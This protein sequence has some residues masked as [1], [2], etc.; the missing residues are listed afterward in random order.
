MDKMPE[1]IDAPT[2]N[3]ENN[4][5]SYEITEPEPELEPEPVEEVVEVV[6]RPKIDNREIFKQKKDSNPLSVEKVKKPKRQISEAQRENLKKAREKALEKRR[7]NAKARK[8]GTLPTKKQQEIIDKKPVVNNIVH[9][10]KN[11][12]NNFSKEDIE[13][14]A[15]NAASKA[16]QR[17]LEEYEMVR[18]HR[19]KEKREKQAAD[20]EKE[21][22]RNT[23]QKA[24]KVEDPFGF[25]F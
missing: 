7:A 18:K 12:T 8:E 23:I 17:A 3:L 11:I 14:I 24:T 13:T 21:K 22:I 16:S 5:I 2:E 20:R 19:K 25:C 4:N 6:P 9:E 15:N 10:T 1:I